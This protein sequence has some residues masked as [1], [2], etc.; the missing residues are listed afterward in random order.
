MT[1][2]WTT[3]RTPRSALRWRMLTILISPRAA[4]LVVFTPDRIALR[5]SIQRSGERELALRQESAGNA[6]QRMRVP[7]R[8]LRIRKHIELARRHYFVT[9]Q[10][11]RAQNA[12]QRI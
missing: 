5:T 1:E 2:S 6:G 11:N 7:S 10:I 3:R 8:T 12:G 4:A 9:Q